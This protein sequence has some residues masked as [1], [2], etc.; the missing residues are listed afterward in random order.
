MSMTAFGLDV[1]FTF[2]RNK[3][4]IIE[5]KYS[6]IYFPTRPIFN[7]GSFETDFTLNLDFRVYLKNNC[8][9]RFG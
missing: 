9:Y 8:V 5:N 1:S 7:L 4:K 2:D 6:S 3:F